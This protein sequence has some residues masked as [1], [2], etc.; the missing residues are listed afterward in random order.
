MCKALLYLWV[1][2][3]AVVGACMCVRCGEKNRDDAF[4][5]AAVKIA[6]F[7]LVNDRFPNQ[8]EFGSVLKDDECSDGGMDGVCIVY[9]E[10]KGEDNTFVLIDNR[11]FD[12]YEYMM[13]PQLVWRD[14]RE[15]PLSEGCR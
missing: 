11:G 2:S 4:V 9:S 7:A 8:E 10:C 14:P 6:D 1:A 15:H 13:W 3:A 12:E 5:R